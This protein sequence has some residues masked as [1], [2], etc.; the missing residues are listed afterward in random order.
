[1]EGFCD[2]HWVDVKLTIDEL[3]IVIRSHNFLWWSILKLWS[4]P[5]IWTMTLHFKISFLCLACFFFEG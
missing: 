2:C 5:S 4:Y 1:V 3:E